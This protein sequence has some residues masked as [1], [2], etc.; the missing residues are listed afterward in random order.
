MA[1]GI[2]SQSIKAGHDLTAS[3]A[4]GPAGR[5]ASVRNC[6]PAPRACRVCGWERAAGELGVLVAWG[7]AAELALAEGVTALEDLGGRKGDATLQ[8]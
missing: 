3:R 6:C 5:K 1:G 7:Q 8:G 4:A 2:K